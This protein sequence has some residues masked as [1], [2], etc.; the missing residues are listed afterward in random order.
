MC[1]CLKTKNYRYNSWRF[2]GI[3]DKSID[4]D[5]G[6]SFIEVNTDKGAEILE[7]SQ[8]SYLLNEGT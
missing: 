6:I 8:I 2:W 7:K 5:I 3:V 1:F 4:D